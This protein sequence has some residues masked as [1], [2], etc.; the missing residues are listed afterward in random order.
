MWEVAEYIGES[1]V[2]IGVIGEICAEWQE[3]H[4]DRLAKA[5]SLVLIVGLAISLAAL[6]GTN[7]SFNGTI[8]SLNL[9]AEEAG[10]RAAKDEVDA[11][12]ARKQADGF[13]SQIADDNAR[14]KSA[15]AKVAAAQA[16]VASA[17]AESKAAA[18]KVATADARIASAE[19]LAAEANRNEAA[20]RVEELRLQAQVAP[21]RL[22]AC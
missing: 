7:E 16:T 11:A 1:L 19:Q 4:K 21:R 9:K 6:I 15:E 18:A 17:E 14:V 8:A 22:R 2:F 12:Q 5:S 13:Q 20:E 3:P 10:E